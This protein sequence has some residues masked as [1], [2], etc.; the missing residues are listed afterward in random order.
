MIFVMYHLLLGWSSQE[1]NELR[2]WHI[3]ARRDA[4]RVW[5]GHVK[6]KDHLQDLDVYIDTI[7]MDLNEMSLERVNTIRS[8]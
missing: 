1:T 2:V 7:K 6:E 5:L 8:G 3:R 4:Y